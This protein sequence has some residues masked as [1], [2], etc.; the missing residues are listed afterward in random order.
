MKYITHPANIINAK[1][2]A[3]L[4]MWVEHSTRKCSTDFDDTL[5]YCSLDVYDF[6][7]EHGVRVLL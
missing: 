1:L 3:D 4:W 2:Y 7:K 5:Q 6:I